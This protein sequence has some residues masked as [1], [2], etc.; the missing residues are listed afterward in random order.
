MVRCTVPRGIC[1]KAL[2]V[3][4]TRKSNWAT[5]LHGQAWPAQMSRTPAQSGRIARR[6]PS[7]RVNTLSGSARFKRY[8]RCIQCVRVPSRDN[9]LRRPQFHSQR[10]A[11]A[12]SR[13][14]RLWTQSS[15]SP[16][17]RTC[18]P[19]NR[20]SS[21]FTACMYWAGGEQSSSKAVRAALAASARNGDMAT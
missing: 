1:V 5:S 4:P 19:R 9:T 12:I 17:I 8:A 6:S 16:R 11:E 20:D 21:P 13:S 10:G 18:P 14:I 3:T 15:L 7:H 2:S